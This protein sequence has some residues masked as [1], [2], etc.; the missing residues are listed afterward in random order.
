MKDSAE[1]VV[2]VI[3]TKLVD[4]VTVADVNAEERVFEADIRSRL[5]VKQFFGEIIQP[6]GPLCLF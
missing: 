5:V 2:E 4:V 3:N 6:L 1:R